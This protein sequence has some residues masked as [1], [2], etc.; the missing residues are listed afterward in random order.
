MTIRVLIVDD[1]PLARDG[2][3]LHLESQGDMEIIGEC[4]NS[5]QTIAFINS[6]QPDLVFLDIKMPGKSGFDVIKEVGADKMPLVIFMTA[7]DQ[8]AIAAFQINALDYLLKPINPT[9]FHES[10]NRARSEIKKKQ[11]THYSQQLNNLLQGLNTESDEVDT[12][13]SQRII[14]RSHGHVYF[15]R[16]QDIQWVEAKGDYVT[17]HTHNRKHL[18]RDTMRNME[19]R[20]EN[21]GFQRI[22]RSLIVKV[23]SIV[24]LTSL[25]SGDYEVV[26]ED[27]TTLKLSRSYRDTLFAYLDPASVL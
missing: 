9:L 27:G 26:I 11:I 7:Y 14:V 13:N 10:L 2:V 20:L 1:E 22:H 8:Y 17:V 19:K 5:A 12:Q 4:S 24:E 15:I 23:D 25:D 16:P 3:K 6:H 18:L 21:A